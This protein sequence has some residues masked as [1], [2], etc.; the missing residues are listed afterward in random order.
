MRVGGGLAVSANDLNSFQIE[1]KGHYNGPEAEKGRRGMAKESGEL[2]QA[3][4][5]TLSQRS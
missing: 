5:A 3:P 1:Q 4:A 2:Q